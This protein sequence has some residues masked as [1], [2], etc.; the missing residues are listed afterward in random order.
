LKKKSE[1]KKQMA[2]ETKVN[3]LSRKM[4][5]VIAIII[6]A[7]ACASVAAAYVLSSQKTSTST[8]NLP[9]MSLTVVGANG[10]Q[11][12]LSEKD[13]AA[14]QSITGKG[15]SIGKGGMAMNIG[16]YTG[17]K[18]S[19]V[20]G[21]VGG[22]TSADTISVNCSDGYTVSFTYDQVANG[23]GFN[24]YD[25]SGNTATPTNPIYL[26]LAYQYNSTNLP[27]GSGPLKTMVIGSD[28]LLSDG[29]IAATMV[30]EVD[31]SSSS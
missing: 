4:L 3:K 11:K 22:I 30:I 2:S 27:S 12:V 9:A 26:I 31:I 25:S 24:T 28:G 16:T 19:D 14:L 1:G 17:V 8:T 15:G 13:I 23:K 7:V 6:I 20:C 18:L 5:A 29:K 10:E 21:L